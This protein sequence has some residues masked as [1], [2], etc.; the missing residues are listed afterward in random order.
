MKEKMWI[1][2]VSLA[3]LL[4]GGAFSAAAESGAVAVAPDKRCGI[5]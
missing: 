4:T 3:L 2:A 1:A 5:R